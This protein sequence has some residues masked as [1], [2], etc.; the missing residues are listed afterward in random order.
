MK[1]QGIIIKGI[2]G[3]YYVKT[4]DALLECYAKGIF[5]KRGQT[6]LAGDMVTVEGDKEETGYVVA[7]IA[8]RKNSF[9]RPPI[10]NVSC[11]FVVVSSVDPRPS[12]SVIDRMTAA[13]AR[14]GVE[15][16]I[17]LTKTDIEPADDL[18]VIYTRAGFA[19]A[20]VQ[21]NRDEALRILAER[22]AGGIAVV[23]G[24]SG[25]GKSTLLNAIAGDLMLET[26]ETSKKL[27][28]GRH[29]TRAVE[30]FPFGDGYLADTPGFSSLETVRGSAEPDEVISW[31]PDIA[32]HAHDCRF[33]D[34]SHTVEPGCTVLEALRAGDIEPTRHQSYLETYRA[35]R[36]DFD[37]RY[38]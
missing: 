18:K 31:F 11:A 38:R 17:V 30:L 21:K 16:V 25:V 27:G 24:N 33:L 2:G 13:C 20:D 36:D 1:Q 4:A 5:R 34:C 22:A 9:L 32:R 23:I 26:G 7:S 10:A 37:N 14:N 12:N 19:V 3:F 6:P 15:P 29:T 28:R 8:P 35:V